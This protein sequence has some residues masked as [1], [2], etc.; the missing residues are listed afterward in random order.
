MSPTR[1]VLM[2]LAS[3][4]ALAA[5]A[6]S[7]GKSYDY[8][9]SSPSG[10]QSTVRSPEPSQHQQDGYDETSNEASGRFDSHDALGSASGDVAPAAPSAEPRESRGRWEAKRRRPSVPRPGA[11]GDAF[12]ILPKPQNQPGLATTWGEKR[13]SAVSTAPFVR[14]NRSH[15][16]A[17]AKLFYND[18]DGIANLSDTHPG[19][20]RSRSSFSVGNGWLGVSLRD[21]RGHFLTGFAHRGDSFVTARSGQR[22]SIIVR[23]HSPSRVEVVVSVDGLDVIDGKSAS[24]A[25]RGYLINPQDSVEIDGFR[26]STREV[27][28]FRFG[29]VRNSYAARKHGDTRNVGVIGIAA[30]N[31]AGD[32][33]RFWGSRRSHEDAVRRRDADPF[34]NRF[35]APPR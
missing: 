2:T 18:A 29:S 3:T 25:K 15:P 20:R 24:F 34:P 35:S 16:F 14:A 17:T 23:N 26:T 5:T 4:L 7:G 1:T 19:N 12:D 8:P 9:A 28:A 27:A 11:D 31:Q 13:F 10:H 30:F 33:P 6:C 22:Y 21:G 32:S